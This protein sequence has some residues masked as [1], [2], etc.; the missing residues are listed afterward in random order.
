MQLK[1]ETI[2]ELLC[3]FLILGLAFSLRIIGID[4]GLPSLYHPDE[5]KYFRLVEGRKVSGTFQGLF[6]DRLYTDFVE[7]IIHIVN[8]ISGSDYYGATNLEAEPYFLWVRVTSVL[9]GTGT[10]L[11]V[12]LIGKMLYNQKVGYLASLLLAVSMLH[13]KDSHYAMY[14]AMMVFFL[15]LSLFFSTRILL[16]GITWN[17]ILAILT[18]GIAALAKLPGAA[19]IFF[20][21]SA[22]ILRIKSHGCSIKPLDSLKFASITRDPSGLRIKINL[23]VTAHLVL[24]LLGLYYGSRYFQSIRTAL[25]ETSITYLFQYEKTGWSWNIPGWIGYLTITS[26]W[27]LGIPLETVIL[28]SLA[29]ALFRHKKADLLLLSFIIP[30]YLFI[31]SWKTHRARDILPLI[32]L[33]MILAGR[34]LYD[35]HGSSLKI[36]KNLPLRKRDV[37]QLLVPSLIIAV[38]SY[39]CLY[40]IAYDYLFLNDS[41]DQ[42][43]EWV[44]NTIPKNSTIA[45]DKYTGLERD[46]QFLGSNF[47]HSLYHVI[48]MGESY[49]NLRWLS[50]S[51]AEYIIISSG[52]YLRYF[53]DQDSEAYKFYHALLNNQSNYQLVKTFE[54]Q[55][56]FHP[57]FKIDYND[58]RALE[59]SVYVTPKISIFKKAD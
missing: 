18:T 10:V 57:L 5:K 49:N 53:L 25:T 21:L 15:V 48:Y 52:Q 34:L 12:Y 22:F 36:R 54:P 56:L 37:A 9:F 23:N 42:V 58:P 6:F 45:V 2:K 24:I 46:H 13:M 35:L 7:L 59:T 43:K 47:S 30:Y 55:P 29:Y 3:I 16:R 27:A 38:V 14:D 33:L 26:P 20:I 11:L 40:C 31:S 8:F 17:G 50:E 1:R 32:P 4:W 39:S 44:V 41:R 28:I 19:G 51:R